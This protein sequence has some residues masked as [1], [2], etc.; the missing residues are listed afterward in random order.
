MRE[1]EKT[2]PNEKKKLKKKKLKFDEIH[3][4]RHR[5]RQGHLH[6]AA[7][8]V[9]QG[10]AQPHGQGRADRAG[11]L[12]G[13]ESGACWTRCV[14][15]FCRKRAAAAAAAVNKGLL[16]KKKKEKNSLSLHSP[17]P[18]PPKIIKTKSTD[19]YAGKASIFPIDAV[20]VPGPEDVKAAV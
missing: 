20:L 16:G 2:H 8:L 19:E 9:A 10:R 15:F 1:R 5:P 11:E 14:F 12:R 7:R 17:S 3:R 18:P 6:E 13:E 4:R